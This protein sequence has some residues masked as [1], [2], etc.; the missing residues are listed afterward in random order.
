MRLSL[1]AKQL[2]T[3]EGAELLG[4]LEAACANGALSE[5]GAATLHEWLLTHRNLDLPAISFLLPICDSFSLAQEPAD[6]VQLAIEQVLPLDLRATARRRR[7]SLLTEARAEKKRQLQDLKAAEREKRKLRKAV[8]SMNF[9]AAGISHNHRAD[10]V[11]RHIMRA[12]E[13]PSVYLLR[14]PGNPYDSHAVRILLSN[15]ADIGYVPRNLA[16]QV[17]ILLLQ[18]LKYR[19]YCSKVLA[20]GR[21][22]IPVIV[23]SFYDARADLEDAVAADQMPA[24]TPA[25]DHRP[26]ETLP[27][28]ETPLAITPPPD[29]DRSITA[30]AFFGILGILAAIYLL[31]R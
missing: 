2:S 12:T 23:I 1:T 19:A 15:G 16:R 13:A 6:R 18:N 3:P 27:D 17:S 4:L 5:S 20:R 8:A 14:E 28:Y 24:R 29:G 11:L 30:I 31:I 21:Y 25:A 10:T 22:P 26:A 9:L 7:L